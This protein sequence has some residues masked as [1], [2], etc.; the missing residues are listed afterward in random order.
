MSF[1]GAD[2]EQLRALATALDRSSADI[3]S[4]RSRIDGMIGS[5]PWRGPDADRFRDEWRERDAADLRRASEA[6]S[7]QARRA[8]DNARDQEQAS[9]SDSGAPQTL[10]AVPTL[11]DLTPMPDGITFTPIPEEGMWDTLPELDLGMPASPTVEPPIES[12][13][14]FRLKGD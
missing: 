7:T 12:L 10:L 5:S 8:R 4:V 1:Y 6:L 11:P 3:D 13:R 2:V 14:E 9:G